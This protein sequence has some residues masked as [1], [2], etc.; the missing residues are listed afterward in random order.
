MG[1]M[2]L[3]LSHLKISHNNT[4]W[5]PLD[6][7]DCLRNGG[8][9]MPAHVQCW[10]NSS[11][12]KYSNLFIYLAFLSMFVWAHREKK[13]NSHLTSNTASFNPGAEPTPGRWDLAHPCPELCLLAASTLCFFHWK[14]SHFNWHERHLRQRTCDWKSGKGEMP[15]VY[16]NNS[17][18]SLFIIKEMHM[19]RQCLC[20]KVIK[21]MLA[22][23]FQTTG[24]YNTQHGLFSKKPQRKQAA[25]PC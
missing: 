23:A 10:Y 2:S 22:M 16:N 15:Q 24:Q 20:S 12:L 11:F 17:M 25:K 4:L 21:H 13:R 7:R 8:A 5:V 6:R 14:G 1:T 19:G 3:R 18:F 9:K